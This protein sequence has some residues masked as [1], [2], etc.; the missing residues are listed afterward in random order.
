[1]F[2]FVGTSKCLRIFSESVYVIYHLSNV[3]FRPIMRTFSGDLRISACSDST[4]HEPNGQC[5][6]NWVSNIN[7]QTNTVVKKKSVIVSHQ[8]TSNDQSTLQLMTENTASGCD[9]STLQL[10][11]E[12]TAS[13]CD[14]STLQLMTENT[15]SGCDHHLV[16]KAGQIKTRPEM[17]TKR[18]RWEQ[19][20]F[21]VY[22]DPEW[23]VQIWTFR[24]RMLA[25]VI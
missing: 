19:K 3:F 4:R 1:M 8:S 9:Q 16:Q 12:N 15:A 6:S 10:M 11:T 2:L 14:Q 23:Q 21:T 22:F 25:S 5:S 7:T 18:E 24:S 17:A 13:D 20:L